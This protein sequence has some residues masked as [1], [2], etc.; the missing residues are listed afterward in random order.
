MHVT[1]YHNPKCETSRNALAIIRE[2]G[3]EPTIIEYLKTPLDPHELRHLIDRMKVP[4]RDVARW[5]QTAEV[6]AAGISETTDDDALLAAMAAHPILMNRPIVITPKGVKLCRPSD[7][8]N[9]LL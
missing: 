3:I 7:S 1:I 4:V 9:E 6:A 5:K 8:V 2:K